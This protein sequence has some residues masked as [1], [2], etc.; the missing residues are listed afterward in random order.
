MLV[1][2]CTSFIYTNERMK[3]DTFL[4]NLSAKVPY[5]MHLSDYEINRTM[6][7]YCAINSKEKTVHQ[8]INA[9]IN[10]INKEI[11]QQRLVISKYDKG[12]T[13]SLYIING[14]E[15]LI[16]YWETAIEKLSEY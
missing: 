12:K 7:Y 2:N 14:L 4:N 8:V 3:I 6:W 15:E 13:E 5:S 11:H 9:A 16:S 10:S 1:N